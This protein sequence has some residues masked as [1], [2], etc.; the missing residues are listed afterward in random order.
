[1]YSSIENNLDKPIHVGN[2]V[3]VSIWVYKMEITL[4]RRGVDIN[5]VNP[6]SVTDVAEMGADIGNGVAGEKLLVGY[7]VD[8]PKDGD[9][10]WWMVD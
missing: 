9:A 6:N 8:T 3:G 4:W 1:M 2:H 10:S 5:W 7:I